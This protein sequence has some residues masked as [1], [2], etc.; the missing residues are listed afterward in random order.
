MATVV[1]LAIRSSVSIVIMVIVI[2]VARRRVL[3]GNVMWC[4][5]SMGTCTL[6]MVLAIILLLV[7]VLTH[8]FIIIEV[9]MGIT[10]AILLL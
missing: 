9:L 8:I 10:P 2:N 1:I 5:W 4:G 3:V 7:I 6:Y